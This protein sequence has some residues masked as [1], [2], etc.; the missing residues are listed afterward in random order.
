MAELQTGDIVRIVIENARVVVNGALLS[1]R[2]PT[3]DGEC[4]V[5]FDLQSESITV[6]RVA[7]DVRLGDLW[8][9]AEG[10]LWFVTED[11][12][13][14]LEMRG[15]AGGTCDPGGLVRTYGPLTLVHRE[16]AES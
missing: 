1:I 4:P 8:R 5:Q 7:P 2:Y 12:A 10:D 9:D 13:E 3:G 11:D 15:T 14:A 6:E 16:G